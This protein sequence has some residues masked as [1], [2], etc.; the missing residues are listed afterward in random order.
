[1]FI[2]PINQGGL[3]TLGAA[4]PLIAVVVLTTVIALC[5]CLNSKDQ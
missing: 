3:L 2:D 4:I 5:A 1:M